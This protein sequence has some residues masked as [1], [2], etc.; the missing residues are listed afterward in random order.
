M[1]RVAVSEWLVVFEFFGISHESLLYRCVHQ[2]IDGIRCRS[3]C[4]QCARGS[5]HQAI[6]F[7]FRANLCVLRRRG[8]NAAGAVNGHPRRFGQCACLRFAPGCLFAVE[9]AHDAPVFCGNCGRNLFAHIRCRCGGCNSHRSLICLDGFSRCAFRG[10]SGCCGCSST[11]HI[12]SEGNFFAF[13]KCIAHHTER[14]GIIDKFIGQP[15]FNGLLAREYGS[16]GIQ[17]RLDRHAR[18]Q[19]NLVGKHLPGRINSGL[20]ISADTGRKFPVRVAINLVIATVNKRDFDALCLERRPVV[21]V[22][23]HHTNGAGAGGLRNQPAC[24]CARNQLT[25]ATVHV[26]RQ[27]PDRLDFAGAG[28][29]VCTV[30]CPCHHAA[31]RIHIQQNTVH[32]RIADGL[33]Q[34]GHNTV[35]PGHARI[36]LQGTGFADQRAG[37]R[38]NSDTVG[39]LVTS[40]LTR[41][42]FFITKQGQWFG[43]L[44]SPQADAGNGVCQPGDAQLA[45]QRTKENPRIGGLKHQRFIKSHAGNMREITQL[46][47][48]LSPPLLISSALI[49]TLRQPM[50]AV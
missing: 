36:R 46:G 12:S 11:F 16:F 25:G 2:V 38:K 9:N 49:Q 15:V 48:H 42:L 7:G 27:R 31:R 50:Q 23:H 37:Y 28:N 19:G 4:C 32:T 1:C 18:I 6:K 35:I 8:E 39:Y 14:V 20:K 13:I 21:A 29:N 41:L 30:K 3:A 47:R 22:R 45:R 34:A 33:L 43:H 17:H 5:L 26:V 40:C 44:C 10:L 24:C